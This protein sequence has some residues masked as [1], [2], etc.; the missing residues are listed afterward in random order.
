MALS[1]V[2]KERYSNLNPQQKNAVDTIDGPLMVVAGPGSGK[3][4]ILSL[5]VANILAQAQVRPN[6]ILCLT[7]TE[8]AAINMRK[9]LVP[10]LGVD[11][12]RVA[13]H[14]F[15]SFCVDVIDR[16]PEYF[17]KGATFVAADELVQIQV[18][19]EILN[20]LPYD[21]P[22]KTVHPEEGFVYLKDAKFAISN[23]KKAGITPEEFSKILDHNEESFAYIN[24]LLDEVFTPRVS[25][26]TIIGV[27]SL[28]KKLKDM[29]NRS[30]NGTSGKNVKKKAVSFPVPHLQS[31]LQSMIDSLELL[32]ARAAEAEKPTALFSEWKSDHLEKV[33]GDKTSNKTEGMLVCKETNR[34]EKLRAL[35]T[36]YA[37]Y[38]ELMWNRGYYDFDDM[39]LDVMLTLEKNETLRYQ[40]QEQ[41]QYVLVDE[42]QDT[43][44]GQMRLLRSITD[45][46]VNEGRP[47]IMVVG[48]DDQAI[49]KFQGAEISNIINFSKLYKDPIIVTMAQN[50][51]S[52]QN[53]LD[54][55]QHVIR[56][57]SQRLETLLP[58]MEK[59]LT[60]KNKKLSKGKIINKNLASREEEYHYVAH[61]IKKL[62]DGGMNPSDIAVI[63]R[64]HDLLESIV[65]HL[66]KAGVPIRYERQQDVLHESHIHQ[67]I[68]IARFAA[69]YA[70]K[71]TEEADY[72]LPEILSYPFWGLQ[73]LDIWNVSIGA[74]NI[75]G[76]ALWLSAM[77]KS[78]NARVREIA[79]FLLDLS[80]RS[81]SEPLEYIVDRIIGAHIKTL[82]TDSDNDS[83]EQNDI[84]ELVS[85]DPFGR[86]DNNSKTFH[87]PFKSFYFSKER[88]EKQKG[89]YLTFLSSLRVFMYAL[90]EYK[91]GEVLSIT[92][93]VSYVDTHEKN[94]L[95]V[96]DNSPYV[97]ALSAVSLLSAHKAKGLEFTAVFV[98]ACQDSVWMSR[99]R[100]SKLSMPINLPIA[101]A[102][103]T[104][105]DKL[106]LF[107]VAL[108]RAKELLYI[109][110]ATSG[111]DGGTELT[112]QFIA[113][114]P[115]G[116]FSNDTGEIELAS[117]HITDIL[118]DSWRVYH[119]PPT[120]I[121]E[122]VL[123]STLVENYQMSVTHL[124]NFLDVTKGGPQNF[125]ET[126]LLRFP[127]AKTASGAYGTAI[128]A[129][130]ERL[131][132]E[133]RGE[134]KVPSIDKVIGYFK[135][136][137]HK[138]RLGAREYSEQEE[139][140]IKNLTVFYKSKKN[141]FKAEHR[142]EVNFKTQGVIVGGAHLTGKIDKIEQ[143]E[144]GQWRVH[145]FKTGSPVHDWKGMTDYEKVKLYKF[146]Q[147]IIFYKLLVEN[148][149]DFIG[150][151]TV[152]TGLIEFVEPDD[153]GHII[154]L[155]L[156]IEPSDIERTKKL[157]SIVYKKI[158]ALDFP[159][160]TKYPL[161]VKGIVAFEDDLLSEA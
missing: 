129:A 61:E 151:H 2:F 35:A 26:E 53:I 121:D 112:L 147:Q 73:R 128:H 9:R 90:R 159:D 99:G 124:N 116:M 119:R 91:K 32:C 23:L 27:E 66:H 154:D 56:K 131:Y 138:E 11:A 10:L 43:N 118:T 100:G 149:R 103:D 101:P 33:S 37:K 25:K 65:P 111:D 39:I 40:I 146:K 104:F 83:D 84:P 150:K 127:Q 102:G 157:I 48:D 60:A 117:P 105:D 52:T 24:P 85:G 156:T 28:I 4:E 6:N 63:S 110:A 5:R 82:D 1:S 76:E 78:E 50:Y 45:A 135:E 64:K 115:T 136:A 158:I 109:T 18:L 95:L 21:N 114:I 89:I 57:G 92:D 93:L 13:I 16:F 41:F 137:L 74:K 20:S 54:L 148:A 142:I 34:I 153:F 67:I 49:Y 30:E 120:T 123:L 88:F 141:T 107:F 126:N 19:E 108:T 36:L 77:R 86:I 130:I 51:R 80:V 132:Y 155:P 160:I 69:S 133:L 94:G 98:L 58:D 31:F 144:D 97:S 22:L 46:P 7:F 81:L 143:L 59:T 75:S 47:N 3:T 72:L 42:F 106:R 38:K 140:G 79:D 161:T 113:D 145:D 15:H 96:T 17:Y 55:A 29:E 68:Q 87:S 44:D 71:D 125:L 139:R 12:Y 152:K 122:S 8:L 134:T 70:R 14:T 62:I